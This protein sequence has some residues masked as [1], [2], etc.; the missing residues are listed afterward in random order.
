M[1]WKRILNGKLD[2][3][4]C[5]W[6]SWSAFGFKRYWSGRLLFFDISKIQ[7]CLDCRVNWIEDMITGKPR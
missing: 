7:I 4:Y 3:R 2:V 1:N 5:K 6:Q